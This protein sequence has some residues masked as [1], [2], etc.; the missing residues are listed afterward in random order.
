M[1]DK[2]NKNDNTKSR[3]KDLKD[4]MSSDP[5]QLDTKDLIPDTI[6]SKIDKNDESVNVIK[7]IDY[8]D[9][10]QN[11]KEFAEQS[12]TNIITTYIKSEKLLDSPRLKDLKQTDI[13]KYIRLLLMLT[14]S[15]S[16]L[17]KLQEFIDCGD[18][19]KEMFDSVNKAQQ[20][21]RSNMKALDEHLNK[22]E[23]YWK[24]YSIQYGFENDEEKIVQESEI[25]NNTEE[26][27]TIIDMSKLTDIINE[28]QDEMKKEKDKK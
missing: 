10:K 17:I 5:V 16:N 21:L 4:L 18:M 2:K 19:S 24:N 3:L 28:R 12:I 9:V 6:F 14:I 27:L 20:E 15:E 26:K 22:C 7:Y 23:T 8:D 13:L 1:D 11:H 25:D